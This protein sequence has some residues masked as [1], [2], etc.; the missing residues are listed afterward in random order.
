MA[1]QHSQFCTGLRNTS[2]LQRGMFAF[3]TSRCDVMGAVLCF[4]LHTARLKA[5][6]DYSLFFPR[7]LE[8]LCCK[9][10]DRC[11]WSSPD[12]GADVGVV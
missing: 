11:H 10:S 12:T 5:L 7:I 2:T 3:M 9:R 8:R 4:Y 6:T 1:A